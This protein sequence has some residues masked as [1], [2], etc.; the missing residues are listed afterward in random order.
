MPFGSMKEH[1]EGLTLAPGLPLSALVCYDSPA[2]LEGT[3]GVRADMFA[4][5]GH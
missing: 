1:A 5:D 3:N 2:R 4:L